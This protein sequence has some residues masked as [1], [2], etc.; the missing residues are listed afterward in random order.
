MN[1]AHFRYS[2]GEIAWQDLN[3]RY[4]CQHPIVPMSGILLVLSLAHTGTIGRPPLPVL[5]HVFGM[6]DCGRLLIV[7]QSESKR[8]PERALDL[9]SNLSCDT[10]QSHYRYVAPL[11][12]HCGVV[13]YAPLGLWKSTA[14]CNVPGARACKIVIKWCSYHSSREHNM[15]TSL[16]YTRE[17]L[18]GVPS[19]TS[20]PLR[21][22]RKTNKCW[23]C[24]ANLES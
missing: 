3:P 21:G 1:S 23:M 5:V 6:L 10:R 9:A 8:W 14:Y 18:Y 17:Y 22:Q 16:C 15:K 20:T 11:G 13:V 7:D 4:Y 12:S 19:A 2:A 24:A